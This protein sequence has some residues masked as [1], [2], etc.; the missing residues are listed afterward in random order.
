MPRTE[1]TRTPPRW[2]WI[3]VTASVVLLL[4]GIIYSTWLHPLMLAQSAARRFQALGATLGFKDLNNPN[5]LDQFVSNAGQGQLAI[6]VSTITFARKS[7]PLLTDADLAYLRVFPDLTALDLENQSVSSEGLGHLVGL[8]LTFLGLHGTPLGSGCS[9]AT[10]SVRSLESLKR[11]PNL[12]WLNLERTCVIDSDLSTLSALP[13]LEHIT[14]GDTR[15]TS[16]GIAHLAKLHHLTFL[17][18]D[19]TQVNDDVG[20]HLAPLKSLMK[21]DLSRTK[22]TGRGLEKLTGRGLWLILR[23][24]ALDDEG[25]RCLSQLSNL[26]RLDIS[27]TRVTPT[28]LQQLKSL[29]HLSKLVMNGPR[30]VDQHLEAVADFPNLS[31]LSLLET[32]VTAA[33]ISQLE[34]IKALSILEIDGHLLQDPQVIE[35]LGRCANLN[36]LLVT[37]DPAARIDKAALQ[38]QL[39]NVNLFISHETGG[40]PGL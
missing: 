25:L 10:A 11:L 15:I 35:S 32:G 21:L 12:E 34:R 1:S 40:V 29:P 31:N 7:P 24:T 8:N 38:H 3:S 23:D 2:I 16:A 30:F 20:T 37:N 33:G 9:P 17:Y 4:F 36:L 5:A 28:G 13:K 26:Y 19:G 22:I 39:P 6:R 27:L 18:L 14:L